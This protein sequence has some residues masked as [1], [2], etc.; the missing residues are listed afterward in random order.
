MLLFT[1][2]VIGLCM[3]PSFNLQDGGGGGGSGVFL[4]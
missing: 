1:D 2:T 3:E 4:K